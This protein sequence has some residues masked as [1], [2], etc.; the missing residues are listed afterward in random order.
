MLWLAAL[1][2][3]KTLRLYQFSSEKDRSGRGLYKKQAAEC[4]AL[5]LLGVKHT[6][7]PV[8]CQGPFQ[9]LYLEHPSL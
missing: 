8:R 4:L 2:T 3:W 6:V 5:G 9:V 7:A 1:S